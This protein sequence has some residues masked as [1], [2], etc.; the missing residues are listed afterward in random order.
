VKLERQIEHLQAQRASE[1]FEIL[2]RGQPADQAA[3]QEWCRRS[4]LHI[5]EFLE[6]SWTDRSLDALDPER[7]VDLDS[8]LRN[9]STTV[10][11]L[12]VPEEVPMQE[13]GRR[14]AR[15]VRMGRWGLAAAVVLGAIGVALFGRFSWR[16]D[17]FAT[18]VGEQRVVELVDNSFVTLNTDSDIQVRFEPQARNIE[19]RRGEAIFKV[20][21]DPTRPFRVHTRAGVV[22]A[23]GTQFNVYDRAQGTDVAVLEGRVRL[24]ALAA[25]STGI[26]ATEELVAGEEA[27]IRLDGS[28]ERVA[29]ADVARVTAWSKRRLKFDDTPLEEMVLEF[30][31]YHRDVRLRIEGVPERSHHYSGIFDADDPEM[32]ATFLAQEPDLR[33]T[34]EQGEIVIRARD[35]A[36]TAGELRAD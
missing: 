28:I 15:R 32:L 5:Q 19:L 9:I 8:L 11:P 27:R 24:T 16:A 1:W 36:G 25:G 7:R 2:K 4:P 29:H 30:N 33:V 21:H 20:A 10:Q 35:R 22:Q 18:R 3:F 12:P 17:E 23:V 31:R 13:R 14:S 34:H 6:I 26:E